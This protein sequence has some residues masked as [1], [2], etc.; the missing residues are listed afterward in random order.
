[1]STETWLQ[2]KLRKSAGRVGYE[3]ERFLIGVNEEIV[4][5]LEDNGITRTELARRLD[6]D[7]SY[8]TRLLNGLPNIT[9]KTLVSVASALGCRM[10]VPRFTKLVLASAEPEV[11][12]APILRF[13][14]PACSTSWRTNLP[15]VSTFR[16]IGD[17]QT[18]AVINDRPS[19][20]VQLDD[21]AAAA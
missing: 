14:R 8:V 12:V 19:L 10:S 16:P 13:A 7:K 4:A 3:M 6:V 9:L 15:P 5:Q 2:S 18:V 1:M 21:P 20:E 17:Q 11:E